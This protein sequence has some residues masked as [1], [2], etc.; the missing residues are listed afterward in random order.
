V[1]TIS[2]AEWNEMTEVQQR[3]LFSK[4]SIHVVGP[5]GD[6]QLKNITSWDKPQQLLPF[7]DLTTF[8]FV[9]GACFMFVFL[10]FASE[11][12]KYR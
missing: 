8:R 2:R 3:E 4:G 12:K 7:L 5:S 11:L 1:H 9:H 10:L 6:Q